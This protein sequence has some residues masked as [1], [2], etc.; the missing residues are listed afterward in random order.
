MRALVWLMALGI[1][2]AG[3]LGAQR[4]A[5]PRDEL[6]RRVEQRFAERLREALDLTP[7]EFEQL[8]AVLEETRRVRRQL[9]AEERRVRFETEEFLR[10]GGDAQKADELLG[11]LE[12]LRERE[13]QLWRDEQQRLAAVLSPE[14]RLR[15]VKLREQFAERVR[16]I[17]M[18]MG[19]RMRDPRGK[20]PRPFPN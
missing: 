6:E 20:A 3:P 2:A 11:R 9:A 16:Q 12:T 14:K 18:E 4:P 15:F 7:E 5:P 10:G 13:L 8:R 1:G 17:R 19:G